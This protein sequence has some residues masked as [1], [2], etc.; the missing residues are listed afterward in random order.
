ME[1]TMAKPRMDR[2]AFVGKLLAE[3][4]GGV[5]REGVRVAR[6]GGMPR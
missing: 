4:D 3:Q 2:P 1:M 6:Q 5:L